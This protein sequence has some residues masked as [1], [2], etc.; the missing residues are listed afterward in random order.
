VSAPAVD[1]NEW[2]SAY[3]RIQKAADTEVLTALRQ[4][5]TD[6]NRMLR[7]LEAQRGI[8]AAVRH[9]QLQTV[10][11]ALLREQALI[12]RRLGSVIAARRI[13]AAEKA[14]ILNG[15]ID[16]VLF[17]AAGRSGVAT[18]LTRSLVAGLESTIEVV[19][20][21]MTQSR[22][23]LSQRVY[24]SE[25]WL[26]GQLEHKINSA[27]ARGLGPHEFAKEARDWIS[28]NTPGGVRYASL[29]LAR[30]EIN[31]AFHAVAVNNSAEKPWVSGVKWNLSRSHPKA[32]LCDAIAGD[33]G[34]G[35]GEGVFPPKDVPRKP[36][37]Q[38]FCFVTPVVID[39]DEFIDQLVAGTYD[40]YL[41][42]K[43]GSRS[44]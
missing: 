35:M 26:R 5:S 24:R 38:C 11:R 19:T 44:R 39:E 28:P 10:K 41:N 17:A 27:L 13:E 40:G 6:I 43:T 7:A 16:A 1:P 23:P 8:G 34:N 22:F 4:A 25:L 2:L 29:R 20:A 9:E 32:D 30:T 42:V 36:H 37:P 18:A 33:D 21:R 14:I 3:A 31:N 15:H 12:F